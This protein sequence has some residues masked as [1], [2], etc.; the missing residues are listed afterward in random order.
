[1]RERE[2]ER[3]RERDICFFFMVSPLPPQRGCPAHPPPEWARSSFPRVEGG[4]FAQCVVAVEVER[5]R[6]PRARGGLACVDL[7]RVLFRCATTQK[8]NP[9]QHKKKGGNRALSPCREEAGGERQR[10]LIESSPTQCLSSPLPPPP[11]Q[12]WSR[13]FSFC[14]LSESIKKKG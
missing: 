8:K 9:T 12:K 14:L 10:V 6:A 7:C 2:R 13:V 11:P 3:L 4:F 5:V 1:M